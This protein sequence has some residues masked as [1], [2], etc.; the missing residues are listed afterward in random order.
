MNGPDSFEIVK[1]IGKG[2]VGRVYLVRHRDTGE[3]YAMKAMSKQEMMKRKKVS[4][5]LI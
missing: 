4:K 2:D 5:Y 3:A 1:L